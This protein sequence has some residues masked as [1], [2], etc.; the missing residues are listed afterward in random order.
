MLQRIVKELSMQHTSGNTISM[1]SVQNLAKSSRLYSR[2]MAIV[3]SLAS[4][5]KKSHNLVNYKRKSKYITKYLTWYSPN[6]SRNLLVW[7]LP[8]YS[9]LQ[10]SWARSCKN[11]K[12]GEWQGLR[13][14]ILPTM[15]KG[16]KC[17]L[18]PCLRPQPKWIYWEYCTK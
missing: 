4:F 16:S 14:H 8:S 5:S 6:Q 3:S 7:I 2:M 9:V 11:A 17:I 13:Y 10:Y 1:Y 12:I 18:I 15:L